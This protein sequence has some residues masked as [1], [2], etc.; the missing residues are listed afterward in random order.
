MKF[1]CALI[2]IATFTV[3]VVSQTVNE[4]LDFNLG[5]EKVAAGEKLPTGWS[6][7]GKGYELKIDNTEKKS[8]N[9]SILIEPMDNIAEKSFGCIAA[10]I[11]ANYP[12]KEIELRGFLKLK[13]VS[14]G[15]AG[16]LLRVNGQNG[17]SLQ[18]NN[19]QERQLTG[20]S[21]WTAYSINLPLPENAAEFLIGALLTGKGQVWANVAPVG[22]KFVRAKL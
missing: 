9:N 10:R 16:L 15:F 4:D 11:P 22:V 1:V 18:F 2:S 6:R 13:D 17:A 20:S 19:R 5:F 3:T 21:N 8:G 14:E 12:G 7:L